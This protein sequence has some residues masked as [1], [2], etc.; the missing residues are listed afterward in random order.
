MPLSNFGQPAG[1]VI[2]V[3]FVVEDIARAMRDFTDRLKVGP[4]FVSGPF[5][6]ARGVYRGAP[7]AMRLT[8][9]VGF[10]GH[11][12]FEVIRAA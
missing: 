7:T 11:M 5:V 3:A 8:L 12:M 1:G 9:A 10:S 6:P 2:Q 4:W